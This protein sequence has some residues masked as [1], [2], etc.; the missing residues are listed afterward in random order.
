M[1]VDENTLS[2][3]SWHYCKDRLIQTNYLLDAETEATLLDDPV[4]F[5]EEEGFGI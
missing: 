3:A 5:E 2:L 4:V 1:H